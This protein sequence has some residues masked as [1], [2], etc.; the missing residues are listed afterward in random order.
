MHKR[1]KKILLFWLKNKRKVGFNI[2]IT[3][4]LAQ[5]IEYYFYDVVL[6]F[7]NAS[8]QIMNSKE[9]KPV[10]MKCKSYTWWIRLGERYKQYRIES[11]KSGLLFL[12]L[13]NPNKHKFI[14]T[15]II[16]DKLEL[17]EQFSRFSEFKPCDSR[18]EI[19]IEFTSL[20][21]VNFNNTR[22]L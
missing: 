22:L 6:I 1:V 15:Q 17:S 18:S 3:I 16:T 13:S 2:Q 19:A 4:N 11:N 12:Y 5:N 7:S 9:D 20:S 10:M 14:G 8:I 21:D